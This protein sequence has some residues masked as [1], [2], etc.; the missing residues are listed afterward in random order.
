MGHRRSEPPPSAVVPLYVLK[1]RAAREDV[2]RLE[3]TAQTENRDPSSLR[4]GPRHRLELIAVVLDLLRAGDSLTVP[5][6]MDVR[7]AAHEQPVHRRER[8][9]ALGRRDARIEADRACAVPFDSGHVQVV[10]AGG[11]VRPRPQ[12][13]DSQCHDDV[14][15]G[16]RTAPISHQE[17]PPRVWHLARQGAWRSGQN[18]AAASPPSAAAA[19]RPSADLVVTRSSRSTYGARVN[20]NS[21]PPSGHDRAVIVPPIASTMFRD[22]STPMPAP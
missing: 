8:L 2:D 22:T 11:E 19:P 6:R 5:T 18:A 1:Q 16:L 10:A 7:T 3:T 20:A 12:V 13:G 15:P 14:G 21:A 4:D 17:P 9:V